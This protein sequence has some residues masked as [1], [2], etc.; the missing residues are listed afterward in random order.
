MRYFRFAFAALAMLL[1]VPA[2]AAGSQIASFFLDTEA[3]IRAKTGLYAGQRAITTDANLNRAQ[4]EWNGSAWVWPA[5]CQSI[6][7]V[8]TDVTAPNDT[9]DNALVT[10][11]LPKLG[12]E[13]GVRVSAL[14]LVA[15]SANSKTLSVKVGSAGSMANGFSLDMVSNGA[16]LN[17]VTEM[18]NRANAASQVWMTNNKAVFG[19]TAA[20]A[21]G[22]T[23]KDFATAGKLLTINSLKSAAAVSAS[24]SVVLSWADVSICGAGI[25]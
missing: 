22:T 5:I 4:M 24:E 2:F 1:T 7:R 14:F 3:N 17:L 8:R 15:S 21:A 19:A 23:T 18:R 10:V 20:A 9:V 6:A 16:S 25:P 11:T 13:D 12:T